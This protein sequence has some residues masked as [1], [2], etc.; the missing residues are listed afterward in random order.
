[1]SSPVAFSPLV[2]AVVLL[3]VAGGHGIVA[4]CLVEDAVV[5]VITSFM[6]TFF[7]GVDF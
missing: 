3:S 4:V 7:R 2:D 6:G 1:M 5:G